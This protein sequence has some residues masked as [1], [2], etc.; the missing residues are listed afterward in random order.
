MHFQIATYHKEHVFF[1]G[2]FKQ[3]LLFLL[4]NKCNSTAVLNVERNNSKIYR[5]TTYPR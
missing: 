1:L 3:L 2:L 5:T 4:L